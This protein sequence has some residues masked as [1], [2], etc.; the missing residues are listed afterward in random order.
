[1]LQIEKIKSKVLEIGKISPLINYTGTKCLTSITLQ[2]MKANDLVKL[3]KNND[4]LT[5]SSQDSKE[6]LITK[7]S[8]TEYLKQLDRIYTKYKEINNEQGVNSLYIAVGFLKWTDGDESLLYSPLVLIPVTIQKSLKMHSKGNYTYSI[9][10]S[11]D[12]IQFN[13]SLHQKLIEEKVKIDIDDITNETDLNEYIL[14]LKNKFSEFG[15]E[16]VEDLVLGIFYNARINIYKDLTQNA[17]KVINHPII[18]AIDGDQSAIPALKVKDKMDDEFKYENTFLPVSYDS[19]QLKAITEAAKGKSLVIEGPP[20]TGKSQ[21]I[22]NIIANAVNHNKTVLFVAEKK[23]ALDVVYNNLKKSHLDDFALYIDSNKANKKNIFNNLYNALIQKPVVLKDEA[24]AVL[25]KLDS[26]KDDLDM[27]C[28][29]INSKVENSTLTFYDLFSRYIEFV[30]SKF[31]NPYIDNINE[32]SLNDFSNR[33]SFIKRYNKYLDDLN[34]NNYKESL[35]YGYL[36]KDISLVIKEKMLTLLNHILELDDLNEYVDEKNIKYSMRCLSIIYKLACEK[37]DYLSPKLFVPATINSL[38]FEINLYFM[39]HNKYENAKEEILKVFDEKVLDTKICGSLH[40]VPNK[41]TDENIKKYKSDIKKNLKLIKKYANTKLT[42]ENVI[43]YTQLLKDYIKA[44]NGYENCE[45]VFKQ[46]SKDNKDYEG[47]SKVCEDIHY[48]VTHTTTN[49]YL[50]IIFDNNNH[51][52]E[53][54]TINEYMNLLEKLNEYYDV[55]VTDFTHLDYNTLIERIKQFIPQIDTL[56]LYNALMKDLS[57]YKSTGILEFIETVNEENIDRN[58]LV[59]IYSKGYFSLLIDSL[60]KKYDIINNFSSVKEGNEIS[61]FTAFDDLYSLISIVKTRENVSS[62]KPNPYSQST[63]SEVGILKSQKDKPTMSIKDLFM[64]IK[65]L[66]LKIKPVMLMSPLSVSTYLPSDIEFDMVIFD[67]ASQIQKEDALCSIYRAKQMIVVGDTEQL[68]PTDFF[69]KVVLGGEEDETID[70]GLAGTSLLDLANT[71]LESVRLKWHYRSRNEELITFSNHYIY[72]DYLIT[73]PIS[74]LKREDEGIEFYYVENGIYDRGGTRVNKEEAKKVSSLIVDN[75]IKYPERSIGVVTFSVVQKNEIIKALNEEINKFK[76][77]D[78]DKYNKLIAYINDES[79]KEPFFVKNIENVQGDERDTIIFSICYG[80]D[81]PDGDIFYNLGRLTRDEGRKRIN[82]AASRSKI[83]MKIVCSFDPETLVISKEEQTGLKALKKFLCFAKTKTIEK[84]EA[85]KETVLISQQII[86][87]IE[88]NL[89]NKGFK[90]ERNLGNSYYKIRL[91]VKNPENENEFILGITLDDNIYCDL[92]SV[93]DRDKLWINVLKIMGWNIYR[94]YSTDYIKNRSLV[95]DKIV[96]TINKNI[97]LN[98]QLKDNKPTINDESYKQFEKE[99]DHGTIIFDSFKETKYDDILDSKDS[100]SE[101]FSKV[102]LRIVQNEGAITLYNLSKRM[103]KFFNVDEVSK[104]VMDLIPTNIKEYGLSKYI[105]KDENFYMTVDSQ[106]KFR[107][108]SYKR[109][110]TEI[111]YKE[112]AD[113]L[114]TIIGKSVGI[115]IEQIQNLL[116]NYL[117]LDTNY[118][119]TDDDKDYITKSF[120]YLISEK[121]IEVAN[122]LFYKL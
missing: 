29:F 28:D 56:G 10:L 1:M 94:V 68:P 14:N 21:T 112:L 104:Q 82:V 34:I 44:K 71:F 9:K 106:N 84:E 19:S 38:C 98:K 103:L 13:I 55:K 40:E 69:K 42:L 2:E 101:K 15:F 102:V 88:K 109:N 86:N 72:N 93:R 3:L 63:K 107:K 33:I 24:Y 92:K 20:G 113:L 100:Y 120:G 53:Y 78:V 121:K 79:V 39:H 66:L 91:G 47:I 36:D 48:L 22:T 119:F 67:E 122:G 25:S 117:D 60:S 97:E 17:D 7:A 89:Q 114:L 96:T 31:V 62:L 54:T 118:Q 16:I 37:E 30:D 26:L 23:A 51:I 58:E 45:S 99:I 76:D 35:F 59:N 57:E 43:L 11:D 4:S 115:S 41:I 81:A 64:N 12:D 74:R 70:D 105:H 77:D 8:K 116:K 80:K 61:D 95:I 75:I 83:N 6:G 111:Y 5:L 65:R 46:I 32:V 27:Y 110:V 85:K 18:K 87:D 49:D 90:T 52:K 73:F 108:S 50:N